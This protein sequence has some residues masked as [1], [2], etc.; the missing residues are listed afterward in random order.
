[1]TNNDYEAALIAIPD[2]QDISILYRYVVNHKDTLKQ[3]L[4]TAIAVKR[5]T[6]VAARYDFDGHGY[7]YIDNGS[8]GDWRTRHADKHD[9]E[10]LY[11]KESEE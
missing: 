7:Q 9:F 1:M 8:G 6:P 5:A 3:A 10:L 11:T 4:T 2:L